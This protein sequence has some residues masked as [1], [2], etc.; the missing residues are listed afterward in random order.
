MNKIKISL[1]AYILFSVSFFLLLTLSIWQLNKN[2]VSNK[3]K[4]SY[5]K[6]I[7][8]QPV[9]IES[10]NREFT[11]YNYLKLKGELLEKKAIF[12][13]PRTLNGVVGYHKI[14]PMKLGKKFILINV[15]FSKTKIKNQSF[16]KPITLQG[17]IINFPRPHFFA[18]ENDIKEDK[19]YTLHKKDI[20]SYMKLDLEPYIFYETGG[21]SKEKFINVLPN[22]IRNI[23]HLQYS[24]TWALLAITMSIIFIIQIRAKNAK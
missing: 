19:W 5:E 16:K 17:I 20:E 21:R 3:T 7:K 2:F 9:L 6:N 23:N 24:I 11:N 22:K 12:M 8:K 1:P 10:L 4:S 15:G 18:L 14:I 13:E